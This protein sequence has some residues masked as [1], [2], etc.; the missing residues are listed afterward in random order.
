MIKAILFDLDGT[1]LAV[2]MDEFLRK[3]FVSLSAHFA[4]LVEPHDFISTLLAS[5]QAMMVNDDP[6]LTNR[7]VFMDDFFRRLSQ[8]PEVIMPMIDSFY[9]NVF[10]ELRQFV[11]VFPEA[12]EIVSAA[13][14]LD[15]RVVIA[16][17]PLFPSR[18]IRH[19]MNWAGISGFDFDL[20][21][22]YENMHYCKPNP[23][24]YLEICSQ[25]GLDP[26][27]CLMVGNDVE[28][29]IAAAANVGMKT[30]FV[31][32][33]AVNK[34][35]IEPL[36]DYTVSVGELKDLLVQIVQSGNGRV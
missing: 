23:N 16:T 28:D 20:V 12:P 33:M 11:S 19:R 9:E 8:P 34:S 1:L 35:G 24:Y 36:A 17:N 21:T 29:D 13:K 22:T 7:E 3:Y 31:N 32:T 15:C 18:A 26:N 2:D 4:H 10:P 25:I 6:H 5:T 27:Q 14:S 30:V